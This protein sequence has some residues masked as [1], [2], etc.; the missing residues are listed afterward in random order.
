MKKVELKKQTVL[1]S[2]LGK[3]YIV[4]FFLPFMAIHYFV[5]WQPLFDEPLLTVVAVFVPLVLLYFIC[6]IIQVASYF[7]QIMH[8]SVGMQKIR[9]ILKIIFSIHREKAYLSRRAQNKEVYVFFQPRNDGDFFDY[10]IEVYS[11]FINN[12]YC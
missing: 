8:S 5:L 12:K 11:I 10:I 3:V 9:N 4:L 7:E 6:K 1:L 2:L